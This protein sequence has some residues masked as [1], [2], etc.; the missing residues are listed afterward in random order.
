[1]GF[2]IKLRQECAHAFAVTPPASDF[3]PEDIALLEKIAR[4]IVNRGMAAPALLFLESLGPLSFLGSQVVYGL[5]P[6][7]DVVIDPAD[8]ERLA[9]LLERRDGIDQLTLC[10]QQRVG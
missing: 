1:M 5:K 3:S 2:W 8:A 6:F 9:I 10:I 7:L 4:L